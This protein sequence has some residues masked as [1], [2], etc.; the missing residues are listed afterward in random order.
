M[1]AR[2][3]AALLLA[4]WRLAGQDHIEVVRIAVIKGTRVIQQN[5][6]ITEPAC[7][8]PVIAERIPKKLL[9]TPAPIPQGATIRQVL[10]NRADGTPGEEVLDNPGFFRALRTHGKIPDAVAFAKR[11]HGALGWFSQ[12]YAG[13]RVLWCQSPSLV[14]VRIP[15]KNLTLVAAIPFDDTNIARLPAALAFFKDVAGMKVAES[16]ELLAR[17]EVREALEKFPQLESAPDVSLLRL[18][19]RLNLPQ[20]E[21]SATAVIKAHPSLPTAWFYYAQYLENNKRYREA[22]ACFEKITQ[23]N[24]PWHNW[25]VEAAK[26]ELTY[27][28]TN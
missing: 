11:E 9:D 13:E 21:T 22:A 10:E 20:T 6:K 19:A 25:T 8:E 28:R 12:D 5:G 26:K 23:H 2:L 24:P 4:G 27:L 17:G 1:S 14:M 16:D 18:F 15:T 7:E 3:I